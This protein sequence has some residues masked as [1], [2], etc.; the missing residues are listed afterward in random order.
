[1][2]AAEVA[3]VILDRASHGA[4]IG[5]GP[6][7]LAVARLLIAGWVSQVTFSWSGGRAPFGGSVGWAPLIG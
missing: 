4:L 1:M 2:M 5:V 3:R 6:G 7:A